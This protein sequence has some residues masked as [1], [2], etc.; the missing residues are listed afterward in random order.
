MGVAEE[1]S[2]NS[3]TGMSPAP[4]RSAK[5]K[6]NWREF[7]PVWWRLVKRN[8]AGRQREELSGQ[9]T[10]GGSKGTLFF[11]LVVTGPGKPAT[12][13]QIAA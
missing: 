7:E 10:G 8:V 6:L 9:A 5:R 4:R 13:R 11:E 12:E 1:N 2:A 3:A